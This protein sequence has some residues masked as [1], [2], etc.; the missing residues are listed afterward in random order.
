MAG[1]KSPNETNEAAMSPGQDVNGRYEADCFWGPVVCKGPFLGDIWGPDVLTC[2]YSRCPL[3][4]SLTR[5]N[6]VLADFA[7]S[8]GRVGP[9]VKFHIPPYP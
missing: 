7:R 5:G 3:L 9:S 1:K 8:A 2:V 4:V 6:R